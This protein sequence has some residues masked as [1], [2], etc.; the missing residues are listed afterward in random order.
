M[1]ELCACNCEE[2]LFHQKGKAKRK[3][4]PLA[5]TW[6]EI[7]FQ[8]R[9][10]PGD[11]VMVIP[12]LSEAEA[13]ALFP[14]GVTTKEVPSGKKYLRYTQLWRRTL[15]QRSALID[16]SLNWQTFY[17]CSHVELAKKQWCTCPIAT[18]EY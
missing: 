9:F 11:K 13:A 2:G 5:I 1:L 3:Q 12:S 8:R 15:R 18:N 17:V 6:I 14:N 16:R 7:L 10:Q 4:K